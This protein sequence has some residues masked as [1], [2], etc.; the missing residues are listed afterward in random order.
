MPRKKNF[1][2][3][4][5]QNKNKII[6]II[7]YN[8]YTLVS[9]AS[10]PVSAFLLEETGIILNYRFSLLKV[11]CLFLSIWSEGKGRRQILSFFLWC[12]RLEIL[13]FLFLPMK[14]YIPVFCYIGCFDTG[15]EEGLSFLPCPQSLMFLVDV[16]ISTASSSSDTVTMKLFSPFNGIISNLSF[17]SKR[18]IFQIFDVFLFLS[19]L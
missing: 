5:Y 17:F 2:K 14:T 7:L 18:K 15:H 13:C 1:K 9:A 3:L 12:H 19:H 11:S 6:K 4:H 10:Q 8:K 16:L